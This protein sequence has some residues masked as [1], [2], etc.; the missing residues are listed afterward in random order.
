MILSKF[1]ILSSP[2]SLMLLWFSIMMR[3]MI[4][5]IMFTEVVS[6]VFGAFVSSF[7]EADHMKV[8]TIISVHLIFSFIS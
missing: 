7:T 8:R 1:Q 4:T 2:S 3:M 6:C 5:L